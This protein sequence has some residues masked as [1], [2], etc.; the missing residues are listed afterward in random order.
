MTAKISRTTETSLEELKRKAAERLSIDRHSLL[1][2]MPFIGSLLM[3]LDL[4]PV[5]DDRLDS[6]ATNGDSIFFDIDF[7]G[8]L[9]PEERLFVLAH[10]AW[11]CALLH[12]AR[13]QDRDP[14]IFNCAADLEIH[15]LLTR[16]GL[17]AP[18]VLPHDPA[19]EG[20]SAEEIYARYMKDAKVIRGHESKNIRNIRQGGGFDTHLSKGEKIDNTSGNSGKKGFDSDFMPVILKGATERCREKLTSVAQQYQRTKGALPSCMQAIIDKVLEPKINWREILTQF[21]TSCYGGS[22]QWLPP[23]RRHVWQGIYMQ[24]SRQERLDAVVAIDTSG[25]T[26]IDL[27]RFFTELGGLLNS[28]GSY[29]MTIIQCDTTIRQIEFFDDITPFPTDYKWKAKGGGGTDFRPVFDYIEEHPEL[30]PNLLIYITDGYGVYPQHAPSIPM[31]WLVT[32]D[33]D[34]DVPWGIVCPFDHA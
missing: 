32:P 33:G 31:M 6:A 16:E 7:Y 11:H 19:W 2:Q 17:K 14:L 18:F 10:E 34:I 25:S 9:T 23:S 27:P 28:F 29:R 3:R 21:V 8:K 15:F 26:I 20:L 1:M 13:C 12:F 5:R 24:S 22:R 4:V 30:E